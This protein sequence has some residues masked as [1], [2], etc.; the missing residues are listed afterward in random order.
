MRRARALLAPAL[1]TAACAG[2]S[3]SWTSGK[4]AIG[5][6][7]PA[8]E[9]ITLHCEAGSMQTIT[10]GNGNFEFQLPPTW[11]HQIS[12]D[13]WEVTA[14]HPDGG[15]QLRVLGGLT[16]EAASAEKELRRKALGKTLLT[17]AWVDERDDEGLT[18][19][20]AFETDES[21]GA[22]RL[23]IRPG[24]YLIVQAEFWSAFDDGCAGRLS[25]MMESVRFL[26]KD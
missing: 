18:A 4:E 6:D 3:V 5:R 12:G 25:A 22:V 11:S 9:P 23:L 21:V 24:G 17:Q 10:A 26:A 8:A 19:D 13:N 20:A 2:S 16:A 15:I 7:A 14:E 1:L